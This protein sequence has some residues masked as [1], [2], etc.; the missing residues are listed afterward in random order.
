MV[1]KWKFVSYKAEHFFVVG[2]DC[3][4]ANWYLNF[5]EFPQEFYSF[6]FAA[7]LSDELIAL[8]SKNTG[9]MEFRKYDGSSG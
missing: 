3:P 9:K 1:N 2:Q 5:L 6:R 7:L 4:I 8:V